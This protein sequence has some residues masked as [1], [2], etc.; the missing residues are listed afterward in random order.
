VPPAPPVPPVTPPVAPATVSKPTPPSKTTISLS[1]RAASPSVKAGGTVA[2]TIVWKN[3]GKATA[4]NVVI[5]DDLPNQMTFVSAKGAAFKNGKACWKRKSVAKGT[6]LTFRVVARVDA[7]VG[8]EQ[9]V[10]V[11]T[12]KASNAKPATAKAP[13]RA[14]R[15]QRTRAGG[16][17]G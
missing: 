9:L 2:F 7:S 11:A 1:K 17:T 14:L 3:T 16:V 13:V 8:N 15:N 6:T 4:K 12:A 10:N 5:C